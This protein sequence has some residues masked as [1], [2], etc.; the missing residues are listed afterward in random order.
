MAKKEDE[1]QKLVDAVGGIIA[2]TSNIDDTQEML[3]A[4]KNAAL[5]RAGIGIMGQRKMGE[6]GYDVASR[7]ISDVAKS[8]ADQLKTY[9]TLASAKTKKKT[10]VTKEARASL[11]DALSVYDK[12]FY[13][14]D[15]YTGALTQ[16]RQDFQELDI[17]PPTQEFFKNNLFTQ[18]YILGQ[19]GQM[20]NY[21]E[22]H[23]AQVLK[24]KSRGEKE[25]PEWEETYNTYNI[26]R[27][28]GM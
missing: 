21:L 14:K 27:N 22:F 2:P 5:I 9:T 15:Q 10:D 18:D 25:T 24:A 13:Q 16:L 1:L 7:T 3:N 17:T 23:K 20:E 4:I 28:M 8:S 19:E 6:S 26:I 12:T 11:K